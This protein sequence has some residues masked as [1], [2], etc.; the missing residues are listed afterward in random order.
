MFHKNSKS[1]STYKFQL[2]KTKTTSP[3]ILQNTKLYNLNLNHLF[4]YYYYSQIILTLV[5]LLSKKSKQ[6][7]RNSYKNKKRRYNFFFN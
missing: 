4:I 7:F 2:N 5:Q 6:I 1:I 3:V